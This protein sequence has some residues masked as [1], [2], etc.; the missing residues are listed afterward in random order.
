MIKEFNCVVPDRL[1]FS[2]VSGNTTASYTYNGPEQLFVAVQKGTGII[3]ND[4]YQPDN[5]AQYDSEFVDIITVDAN[6]DTA[7][8]FLLSDNPITGEDYIF[9]AELLSDG[10]SYE[11]RKNPSL[12]DYYQLSHYDYQQKKFIYRV[13]ERPWKTKNLKRAET[14]IQYIQTAILARIDIDN[15]GNQ[16]VKQFFTEKGFFQ[17]DNPDTI[18]QTIN[19][20]VTL[21]ENF[22]NTEKN[23]ITWK[24]VNGAPETEFP[25]LPE[26]FRSFL[27]E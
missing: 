6:I 11:N 16:A 1:Y 14:I 4:R 24:Y 26:F 23:I 21:L 2:E 13:I 8:A 27:E 17:S 19:N 25:E 22:I 3:L 20:C 12:H 15:G 18:V 7:T 10:T 5:T 9:E